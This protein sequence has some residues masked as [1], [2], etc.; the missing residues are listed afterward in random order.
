M[1]TSG[2]DIAQWIRMVCVL[3]GQ[4]YKYVLFVKNMTV[5]MHCYSKI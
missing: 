3:I 4:K 5:I 2:A 1:A